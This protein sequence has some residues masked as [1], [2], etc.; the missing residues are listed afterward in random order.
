MEIGRLSAMFLEKPVKQESKYKLISYTDIGH[1]H[2][3][4]IDCEC[5]DGFHIFGITHG[6]EIRCIL[7]DEEYPEYSFEYIIKTHLVKE[8]LVVVSD[9]LMTLTHAD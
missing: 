9:I 3:L 2:D 6:E 5:F 4:A 1:K 7:F 8:N